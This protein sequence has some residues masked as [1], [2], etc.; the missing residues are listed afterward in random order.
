MMQKLM[1]EVCLMGVLLTSCVL[2]GCAVKPTPSNTEKA[3][4]AAKPEFCTTALPIY[5]GKDDK[6]TD[7]T[8]RQILQHNKTGR[9]LCKW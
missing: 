4:A 6:I 8:A 2:I 5:I 7:A 9:R 1:H 3:I